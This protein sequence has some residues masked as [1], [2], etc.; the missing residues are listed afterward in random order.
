M[1]IF[2]KI[3]GFL[4][5]FSCFY[6]AKADEGMWTISQLDK[7]L[8]Q[9]MRKTGLKL[10]TDD[11]Y[12]EKSP[13][14]K[15]AVMLF[16]NAGTAEFVS[17]KGLIF[18]NHHCGRGRVQ[19]VSTDAQN[20]L[21][22]GF[23]A[24]SQAEEIPIKGLTVRVFIKQ[25]DVT[26]QATQ[27]LKTKGWRKVMSEMEKQYTDANQ[28]Y[29][30]SL[31]GY[32]NGD[33]ILSIFQVFKD[34]RLVGV[35]PESIG[36]FG[37]ETDNFEWPRHSADF[38]IFRVYADANNLPANYSESNKPYQPKAFLPIS[39]SGVHEKD[40]AMVLGFPFM[41]QRHISSFDLMEKLNVENH[42]TVVTK[43]KYIEVLEK[44]MN[45]D[46]S[47]RLKY[48]DKNFSAG[49]VYKLSLGTLK[50]VGLSSA[51]RDK[52]LEEKTF[53]TW[54]K[55]DTAR[56]R[57]YGNCLPTLEQNFKLEREAKYAHE[58]MTGAL[59]NDPSLF[60]IRSRGLVEALEKQDA[61]EI[62][63]QAE[64]YRKWYQDFSKEY[65]ATTDQAVVRSM[66][67]LLK[68]EMKKEY[69][70]DFYNTIDSTYQGNI[71][72]YVDDL[73]AKS[74]F[75]S[76]S[77]IDLFLQH[78]DLSIKQD[79][80]YLFGVSVFNKLMDVKKVYAKND[81][82]IRNAKKQYKEGM[83]EKNKGSLTYPDANFSLRLTYGTVAG[84]NPRDGLSYKSR[85]TLKGVVEK[86]D[87]TH[88]EFFVS[89][90]LKD[91]YFSKDFGRYGEN[92][93]MY[94]DF[95]TTTDITGGNS[96]SPV[97]NGKGELIGIAFD[98]NWESLAGSMIY[99]PEKNRTVNVDIRYALFIVDKFAHSSYIINEL[100]IK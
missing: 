7:A 94:V 48:S 100:T 60:G 43:G 1:N 88:Y 6:Y 84:A 13:S 69:L 10:S 9:Q 53:Q 62:D 55:A 49:N 8:M 74:I 18:T 86:E 81:E 93:E 68:K 47:I 99:E 89:P 80:L 87:S 3:A 28:G 66:L 39:L 25:M 56:I 64:R 36:N 54:I 59:F 34:V 70:P 58:L 4:L 24:K 65:D 76:S 73:Y 16:D 30:A 32:S 21:R 5:F 78:P 29:E 46:E 92:D 22:D 38:S 72:H 52:Q 98:G 26:E 61:S 50:Q 77:K 79:P 96:G 19:E 91:L 44:E 27:L 14:L 42:A 75:S 41:T 33:Y 57:K 37:G 90:K 85:T 11:I 83:R 31:D 2:R 97:L 35:P 63:Q 40:F 23:W 67:K 51:L 20:Y 15:D 82:L 45:K 95:L 12:N 17:D 71:D